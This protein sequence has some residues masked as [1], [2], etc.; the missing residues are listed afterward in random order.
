VRCSIPIIAQDGNHLTAA[1]TNRRP[2]A[3]WLIAVAFGCV[4]LFWGSTYTAIAVSDRYL[5]ALV[6]G[7]TRFLI[8]GVLMLAWCRWRGLRLWH[9]AR[10]MG[11]IAVIGLLLLGCGNTALIWSERYV[12]SG[13]SSLIVAIV[14]LYVAVLGLLLPHGERLRSR[15]WMGLALGMVGLIALLWPSMHE[16]AAGQGSALVGAGVLLAGSFCWAVG[17]LL[18]RELKLPVNPMVAAGW[19]MLAA[20]AIDAILAT[21]FRQWLGAHWTGAAWGAVWYL[22]TFGS[23][24]GFTAYIWLIEHVPVPKVAT[25]AYVNPVVAVILGAVILH[26]RMQPTEYIGMVAVLAA[27][28]LVTSSQLRSGKP[29]ADLECAAVESEG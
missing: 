16:R 17:S 3:A 21:T 22:V 26:E 9:S 13:L 12:A 10:E 6:L 7:A 4:Y 11:W 2:P 15:G 18:S 25:Y 5:P 14:P 8:A 19:E 23:L 1:T 28:A 24:V 27:V 20:G 29:A